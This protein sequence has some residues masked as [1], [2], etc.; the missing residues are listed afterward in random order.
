MPV[1]DMIESTMLHTFHTPTTVALRL[2][3]R[4]AYVGEALRRIWSSLRCYK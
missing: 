1:F 4:S 2:V 3:T